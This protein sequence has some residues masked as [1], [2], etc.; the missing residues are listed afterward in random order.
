[1][2]DAF[3]ARPVINS[4]Y[5]C[6][7]RHWEL[8]N[9]QPTQRVIES[10]RRAEFVTPI[11]KP[12]KRKRARGGDGQA[13]LGLDGGAAAAAANHH[14]REGR[15]PRPRPPRDPV[16]PRGGLPHGASRRADHGHEILEHRPGGGDQ[17]GA[18]RP[19]HD[20]ERAS[21]GNPERGGAPPSRKVVDHGPAATPGKRHGEHAALAGTECPGHHLLRRGFVRDDLEPCH[22]GRGTG[23]RIGPPA[24]A[25]FLGHGIKFNSDFQ[26]STTSRDVKDGKTDHIT[27]EPEQVKAFRDTWRDGIHSYLTYLRDRLTVARDLLTESGPIFVQIGDEN[28]HRVRAVMDEVFGNENC[29]GQIAFKTTTGA[30]S[31]AV[32]TNVLASVTHHILWFARNHECV[33]YRQAYQ[34]KSLNGAGGNA[35]T[36]VQ[37]PDGTR[38]NLTQED[39]LSPNTNDRVLSADNLASQ[40]T[41]VVQTT[42]FPVER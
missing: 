9:G 17:A 30:G 7:G 27:R 24:P 29:I 11:P 36:R 6:P 21:H 10:R 19:E 31:F 41:R 2:S 22:V 16:S 38:R 35:Y 34:A 33:K 40:T 32:G 14:G 5:E 39:L 18:P 8:E 23:G 15:Q 26:R 13:D 20:A 42:V 37:L 25:D 4:P 3:F 28:V 12:K 1:M